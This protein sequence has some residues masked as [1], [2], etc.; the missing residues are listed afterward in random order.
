LKLTRV[1]AW[2]LRFVDN[3][4]SH[5]QERRKG[6]LSPE[7]LQNAE[8]RIIRAAQQEEF[9]EEYRAC[10]SREQAYSKE[11]LFD[12]ANAKD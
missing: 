2:V 12:K 10:T 5:R 7:E 6:S 8:I 11:E 9:F 4:R 1:V 3:C